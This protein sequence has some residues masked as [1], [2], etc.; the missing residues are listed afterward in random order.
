MLGDKVTLRQ[1]LLAARRSRTP[2]ELTAARS[3]IRAAVLS[4]ARALRWSAVAAYVPMATE[5]GSVELLDGLAG[6]EVRVI[7][8]VVLGDRD[9]S[10]SAWAADAGELGVEAITTVDA[11][12]V[13]ALAVA[14][15]GTR[16]GRGGGSYDRALA[17]TRAGVPIAALLFDGELVDALPRDP[18]DLPVS[19]VVTPA[20][21]RD[22]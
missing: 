15:D 21:W 17:R 12:L 19:A 4:Q 18:W 3:G 22:L 13:P 2:D 11:V 1:R 16:L 5:P 20:G 8:P 14:G 6:L 10:W 7:V 9:L